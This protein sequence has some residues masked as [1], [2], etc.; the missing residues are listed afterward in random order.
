MKARDDRLVILLSRWGVPGDWNA[1][2]AFGF[3]MLIIESC[4][5]GVDRSGLTDGFDS[6]D[7]N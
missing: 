2:S 5:Y 4:G 3:E 6:H 7:S 1:P